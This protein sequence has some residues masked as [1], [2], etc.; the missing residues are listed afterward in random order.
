MP[1]ASVQYDQCMKNYVLVALC[2]VAIITVVIDVLLIHVQPAMA[3]GR[4]VVRVQLVQAGDG[5]SV[6]G[7]V[8]GFSCTQQ[9]CF[10]ATKQTR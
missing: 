9:E 3:Q 10:I 5:V 8:V 2:F 4:T 6:Q 1:G 7:D